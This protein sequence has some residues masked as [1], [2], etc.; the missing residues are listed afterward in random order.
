MESYLSFQSLKVMMVFT[1]MMTF[2]AESLWF[3]G[4]GSTPVSQKLKW[5]PL[6][7]K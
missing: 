3:R 2:L 4:Q 5:P 1:T 6:H 7:L